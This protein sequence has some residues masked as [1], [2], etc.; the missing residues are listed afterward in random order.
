MSS[1]QARA[2][3][4]VR[5][6]TIP[7]ES[8]GKLLESGPHSHRTLHHSTPQPQ[9]YLYYVFHFLIMDQ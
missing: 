8:V 5:T 2:S 6:T 9:L 7:V 4:V 3:P 1:Q